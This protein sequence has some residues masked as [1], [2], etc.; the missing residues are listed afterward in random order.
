[1]PR[2][3]QCRYTGDFIPVDDAA[4][5]LHKTASIQGDIESFVSPIDG[6]VI[7]DRKQ[8][9]EHNKRHGVVNADEFTPEFYEKKA[10]ERADVYEGR[11]S[12]EETYK[13]KQEIYNI[14]VRAE[15]NG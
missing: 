1:M 8:Y 7:T 4:R 15:E 9:R 12:R 11:H 10:K 14:M 2:W 3:R 5:A 13:R 6:T